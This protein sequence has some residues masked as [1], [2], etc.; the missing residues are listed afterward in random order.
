MY[1]CICIYQWE[2]AEAFQSLFI[3]TIYIG[4]YMFKYTLWKCFERNFEWSSVKILWAEAFYIQHWQTTSDFCKWW[5]F[6]TFLQNSFCWVL[7]IDNILWSSG[8]CR[9]KFVKMRTFAWGALLKLERG[10]Q[11]RFAMLLNLDELQTLS[12]ISEGI[13]FSEIF[14]KKIKIICFLQSR[15]LPV[16]NQ[17]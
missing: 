6:Y 12:Q 14:A 13:F 2:K 9:F 15:P 1:I 3:S 11:F 8:S 5:S 17:E 4:I 16:M 7:Q 10:L